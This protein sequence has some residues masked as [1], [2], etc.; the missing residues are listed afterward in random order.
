[1]SQLSN[2]SRC[3]SDAQEWG[4]EQLRRRRW[5]APLPSRCLP[6]PT[7]R[8]PKISPTVTGTSSLVSA[9]P[10]YSQHHPLF[11]LHIMLAGAKGFDL[12]YTH[13]NWWKEI[14]LIRHCQFTS[15]CNNV[16]ILGCW[17]C[18]YVKRVKKK[19]IIFFKDSIKCF[20]PVKVVIQCQYG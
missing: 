16:K 15:S 17:R 8:R 9:P 4:G 7:V 12:S 13:S 5:A 18:W 11:N 2:T 19:I 10:H 6:C 3:A 14:T 1:M 20:T